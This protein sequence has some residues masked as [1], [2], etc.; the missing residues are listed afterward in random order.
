MGGKG[1]HR[2]GGTRSSSE[3]GDIRRC[4]SRHSHRYGAA[5]DAEEEAVKLIVLTVRLSGSMSSR[6]Y[7]Y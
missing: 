1:G 4:S 7:F 5:V 2:G 6:R 3:S